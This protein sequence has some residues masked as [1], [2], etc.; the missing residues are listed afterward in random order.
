MR[1]NRRTRQRIMLLYERGQHREAAAFIRRI[2]PPTYRQIVTELPMDRFVDSMPHSMPV[3]EAIYAKVRVALGLISLRNCRTSTALSS[4]DMWQPCRRFLGL[5]G[6]KQRHAHHVRPP[7]RQV[8]ASVCR[9][10]GEMAE[11]PAQLEYVERF[12]HLA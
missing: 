8:L 12:L 2:S 10:A 5:L 11:S 7:Q 3:L 4:Q 1:L 9:L 6:I